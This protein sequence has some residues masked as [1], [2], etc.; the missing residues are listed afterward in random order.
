MIALGNLIKIDSEMQ[1]TLAANHLDLV[2]E[3][4]SDSS[5]QRWKK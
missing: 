5:I 2:R 4:G 3:S 1:R